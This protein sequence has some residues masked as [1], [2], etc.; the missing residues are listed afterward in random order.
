MCES[1]EVFHLKLLFTSKSGIHKEWHTH[2][3]DKIV[4]V[5]QVGAAVHT[6][7]AAVARVQVSL[8]CLGFR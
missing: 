2:L 1:H 8:E 6:A 3:G 5:G 4:M 7:V